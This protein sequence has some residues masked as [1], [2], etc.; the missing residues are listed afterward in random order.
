M[1]AKITVRLEPAVALIGD[2]VVTASAEPIR[3][4]KFLLALCAAGAFVLS[5]T[6]RVNANW[7][8]TVGVPVSEPL[9]PRLSPA[10]RAP[11]ETDQ[12]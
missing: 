1:A 8:A 11:E 7:P 3:S 12:E 4:V 10:G 2:V 5:T 9:D 6:L